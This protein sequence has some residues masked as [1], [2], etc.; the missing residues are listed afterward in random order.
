MAA[1]S[2]TKQE[3]SSETSLEASKAA[4]EPAPVVVD[5]DGKR[6]FG[7]RADTVKIRSPLSIKPRA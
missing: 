4:S 1:S 5:N 7:I 3:Q 2:Q 6:H